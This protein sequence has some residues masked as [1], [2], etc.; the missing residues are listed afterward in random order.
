MTEQSVGHFESQQPQREARTP[1]EMKARN[2]TQIEVMQILGYI[3]HNLSDDQQVAL[4]MQ[5]SKSG[6]PQ[7]AK[8]YDENGLRDAKEIAQQMK[9]QAVHH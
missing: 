2:S 5:W 4:A 1:K 9:D 7:F 3:D 8:L 6:S